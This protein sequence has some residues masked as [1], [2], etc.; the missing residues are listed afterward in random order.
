MR[1]YSL[2]GELD[3]SLLVPDFPKQIQRNSVGCWL[4][5]V[6]CWLFGPEYVFV[7]VG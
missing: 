4:L 3:T 6:G 2:E 1:F 7:N 5:V